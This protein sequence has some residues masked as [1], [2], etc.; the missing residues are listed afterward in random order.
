MLKLNRE[1]VDCKMIFK[2]SDKA[3]TITGDI[4]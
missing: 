2:Q 1:T 4:H 3:K